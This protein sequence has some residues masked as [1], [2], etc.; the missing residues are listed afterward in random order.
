MVIAGNTAIGGYREEIVR[1]DEEWEWK[2]LRRGE[3]WKGVYR[4][5]VASLRLWATWVCPRVSEMATGFVG[6]S[7]IGNVE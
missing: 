1:C 5:V 2:V 3:I 4:F 6:V 7:E